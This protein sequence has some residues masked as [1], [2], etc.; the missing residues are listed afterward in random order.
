METNKYA[1]EKLKKLRLRK[2]LTQQELA[3]DLNIE[4]KQISR[5]ESGQRQ[6]KPDFLAKLS[7][8]FNV[9]ISDFF[10]EKLEENKQTDFIPVY[11]SMNFKQI[12]EYLEVPKAWLK[13]NSNV[14]CVK[15]NGDIILYKKDNN[16]YLIFD[17]K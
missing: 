10:S 9:P 6:F 14:L 4:Q 16:E 17:R 7:E 13:G 12:K 2:N 3:E 15:L 8:Y 5:Y 1:S 11:E